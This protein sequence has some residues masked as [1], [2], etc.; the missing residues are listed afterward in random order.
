[1]PPRT[2]PGAIWSP[3]LPRRPDVGLGQE[4]RAALLPQAHHDVAQQPT[5]SLGVVDALGRQPRLPRARSSP[6]CFSRPRCTRRLIARRRLPA[7]RKMTWNAA[8]G[9]RRRPGGTPSGIRDRARP[10]SQPRSAARRD[11]LEDPLLLAPQQL[12]NSASCPRAAAGRHRLRDA[13]RGVASAPVARS[14]KTS[15]ASRIIGR[16]ARA[17]GARPAVATRARVGGRGPAAALPPS[18]PALRAAAAV[19]ASRRSRV[20][21]GMTRGRGRARQVAW[22][23]QR[24][25]GLD[26]YRQTGSLVGTRTRRTPR[27]RWGRRTIDERLHLAGFRDAPD[28]RY[29]VRVRRVE[30][31][32]DVHHRPR[33]PPPSGPPP[34]LAPFVPSQPPRRSRRMQPRH[35]ARRRRGSW[36][37]SKS[38]GAAVNNG[39]RSVRLRGCQ[40][41]RAPARG[42]PG[43][44]GILAAAVSRPT[45]RDPTS[46]VSAG[47]SSSAMHSY[48]SGIRCGMSSLAMRTPPEAFVKS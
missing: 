36:K 27:K 41:G 43:R 32:T 42:C 10:P 45:A 22:A 35:S 8:G 23:A 13:H 30:G 24:G 20:G 17:P 37:P 46:G 48:L 39:P 9:N 38:T 29:A 33:A 40:G 14:R 26:T 12:P 19:W 6:I 16:L 4:A 11:R 15:T 21:L 18:P 34:T 1:M 31:A 2:S 47:P 5:V 28:R 3:Q 44:T 25:N 7:P